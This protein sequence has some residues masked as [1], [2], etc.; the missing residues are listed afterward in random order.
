MAEPLWTILQNKA[1]KV[2]DHESNTMQDSNTI[3]Q[4]KGWTKDNDCDTSASQLSEYGANNILLQ[5][6]AE[7]LQRP[8]T[9]VRVSKPMDEAPETP[10]TGNVIQPL[11]KNYV[12]TQVNQLSTFER[13]ILTHYDPLSKFNPKKWVVPYPIQFQHCT[14]KRTFM[15]YLAVRISV[16]KPSGKKVISNVRESLSLVTDQVKILLENLQMVDPSIIFLPHKAKD[17][18]GVESDLIEKAGLMMFI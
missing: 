16:N 6:L 9:P 8:Y 18:V 7:P 13:S 14:V 1:T 4:Q 5:P 11:V 3:I 12:P 10:K 17:R 15:A 2:V